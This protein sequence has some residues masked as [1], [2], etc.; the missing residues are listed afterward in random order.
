MREERAAEQRKEESEEPEE[1]K[2]E[3]EEPKELE[4]ELASPADEVWPK[5]IPEADLEA[6][7]DAA[8]KVAPNPEEEGPRERTDS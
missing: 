4:E 3:P 5:Q 6:R 2:E 7:R 8:P 1:Q